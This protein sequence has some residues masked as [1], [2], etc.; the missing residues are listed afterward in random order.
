ME[1]LFT[2]KFFAIDMTQFG[3]RNPFDMFESKEKNIRIKKERRKESL[4]EI[5]WKYKWDNAKNERKKD[6]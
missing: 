5:L 4:I 3:N 6:N 1:C 2:L